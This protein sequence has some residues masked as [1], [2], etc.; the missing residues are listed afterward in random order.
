MG[1]ARR[2]VG[3]VTEIPLGTMKRV[4]IGE[5]WVCVVHA[6][7]GKLYAID[8]RCTHEGDSLSQGEIW[9]MEVECPRHISRFDVRTG[10]VTAPPAL[11]PVE[12]YA[13]SVENGN[14]YVEVPTLPSPP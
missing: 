7:D 4:L 5:V 9:G 3:A 2:K 8:D 12:T 11:I 6:P 14:V 13:V 1:V 10:A